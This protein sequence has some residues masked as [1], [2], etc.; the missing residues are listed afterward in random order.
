MAKNDNDS[1]RSTSF[2]DTWQNNELLYWV[3]YLLKQV[4]YCT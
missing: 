4:S 1:M 3:L 2:W